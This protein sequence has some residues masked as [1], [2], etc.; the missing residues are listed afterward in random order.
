LLRRQAEL[1]GRVD[2]VLRFVDESLNDGCRGHV[3]P[4]LSSPKHAS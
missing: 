3:Q 2:R 1:A 4:Y